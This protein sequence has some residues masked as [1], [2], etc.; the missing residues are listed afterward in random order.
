[1]AGE[2]QEPD[3]R[4]MALD[5]FRA[6]E[7]SDP[8]S[9]FYERVLERPAINWPRDLLLLAGIALCSGISVFLFRIASLPL[10]CKVLGTIMLY[11]LFFVIHAKVII[12]EL[13]LLYQHFAPAS[14]RKKCRFEP[15]CSQ[16]MLLSVQKYGVI[17]GVRKGWKRLKRCKPPNGGYDEP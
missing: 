9:F 13:I 14:I 1:M 6:A 10:W 4:Q 11:C 3:F 5:T 16:Y 8:R 15:S 7:E 12:I 2:S 17:K